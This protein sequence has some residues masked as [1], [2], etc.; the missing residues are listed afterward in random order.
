MT[1]T[2]LSAPA[3]DSDVPIPQ[4]E[5]LEEAIETSNCD[6]LRQ[7]LALGFDLNDV[8]LAR[9]HQRP[10][11]AFSAH[12]TDSSNFPGCTPLLILAAKNAGAGNTEILRLLLEAGADPRKHIN[13]QG[14]T[15]LMKAGSVELAK[16]LIAHGDDVNASTPKQWRPVYSAVIARNLDLLALLHEHGALLEVTSREGHSLMHM[17]IKCIP[18]CKWLAHQAPQLLNRRRDDG[19]KHGETPLFCA[20]RAGDLETTKEL[21][22][23]GSDLQMQG[24]MSHDA[25]SYARY[26]SQYDVMQWLQAFQNAQAASDVLRSLAHTHPIAAPKVAP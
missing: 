20:I 23:L 15:P 5:L 8:R 4:I 16:L 26:H 22:S 6:L 13:S 12:L 7:W 25:V 17:A 21:V 18:M 14:Y 10:L 1:S 9:P 24:D 2:T 19:T 3:T 11:S